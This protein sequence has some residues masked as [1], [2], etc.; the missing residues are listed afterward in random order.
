MQMGVTRTVMFPCTVGSYEAE[1]KM[2][3][4]VV[5]C[6]ILNACSRGVKRLVRIHAVICLRCVGANAMSWN[7]CASLK[8]R[9][10]KE[11]DHV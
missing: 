9:E 8:C 10:C 11:S 1:G 4:T 6:F 7:V 2:L 5:L 3:V